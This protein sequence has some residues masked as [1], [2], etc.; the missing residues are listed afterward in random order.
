MGERRLAPAVVTTIYVASIALFVLLWQVAS[1]SFSL[2]RLFPGPARTAS[3]F[4][5]LALSG[6]LISD[7]QASLLRILAGLVIG[8][9]IGV[10]A[11]LLMGTSRVVH[12]ILDPFVNF[13]RFLSGIAWLGM[14]TL[15]LGL[16]EAPK[17]ALVAYVAIFPVALNTYAGYRAIP[18]NRLRAARAMGATPAQIFRLVALPSVLPFVLLGLRVAVQNAFLTVVAAELIAAT[19]GLGFMIQSARLNLAVDVMFA[20]IFTL[21]A[22][23]FAADRLISKASS[24]LVK[25]RLD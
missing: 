18:L 8:T 25:Y 4:V 7:A 16:G 14:A 12:A 11:G 1:A 6:T 10:L 2:P 9:G 3:T 5:E 13:F 15:W 21:A 23:G 24:V 19:E 17:I 22:L 20:G